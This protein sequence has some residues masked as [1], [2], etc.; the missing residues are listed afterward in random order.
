MELSYLSSQVGAVKVNVKVYVQWARFNYR[1]VKS[2]CK[3]IDQI[4]DISESELQKAKG[5]WP[6]K[7]T[8]EPKQ[9]MLAGGGGIQKCAFLKYSLSSCFAHIFSL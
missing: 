3:V 1:A 7:S 9:V 4:Q 6:R 8:T 2:K 5:K